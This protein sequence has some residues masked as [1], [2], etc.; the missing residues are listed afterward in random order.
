MTVSFISKLINCLQTTAKD[1]G[2]NLKDNMPLWTAIV[3]AMPPDL[4]D[5][6]PHEYNALN[7]LKQYM[8]VIPLVTSDPI[9]WPKLASAFS[10]APNLQTFSLYAKTQNALSVFQDDELQDDDESQDT[11]LSDLDGENYNTTDDDHSFARESCCGALDIIKTIMKKPVYNDR[12]LR[13]HIFKDF[14]KSRDYFRV[15]FSPKD[16]F[17]QTVLKAIC[18]EIFDFPI[19]STDGISNQNGP[20]DTDV[21][22][23]EE[24]PLTGIIPEGVLDRERTFLKSDKMKAR[25]TDNFSSQTNVA[26][27][28]HARV[29]ETNFPRRQVSWIK[30]YNGP[31]KVLNPNNNVTSDKISARFRTIKANMEEEGFKLIY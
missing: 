30:F 22:N 20:G 3:L 18:K 27:W 6:H 1:N 26:M 9:Y 2:G 15:L 8:D 24:A 10:K 21:L 16:E 29:W 4:Q 13:N 5:T 11:Q 17:Q 19:S 25:N 31:Y 12:V 23:E 7:D 28:E 14:V